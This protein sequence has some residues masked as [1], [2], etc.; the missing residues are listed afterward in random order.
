MVD[1][2][3]D[4]SQRIKFAAECF[5]EWGPVPTR[6]PRGTILGPWLFVLMIN[7]LDADTQ[8]WKYVDDTRGIRGNNK[9]WGKSRPSYS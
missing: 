8:L 4:R 5:S 1:F 2:L 7:D 9:G 3:S 6:V